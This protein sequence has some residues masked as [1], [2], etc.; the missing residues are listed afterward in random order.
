MPGILHL[1]VSFYSF[2]Q[3][4]LIHWYKD[5]IRLSNYASNTSPCNVSHKQYGKTVI[6]P[7]HNV[8]IVIR[9]A[10]VLSGTY[11]VIIGNDIGHTTQTIQVN[12]NIQS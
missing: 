5:G 1:T 3:H 4:R 7:G 8:T 6:M 11:Q 12:G 10:L 9:D 2:P